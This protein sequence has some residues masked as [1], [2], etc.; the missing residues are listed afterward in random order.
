VITRIQICREARKTDCGKIKQVSFS[1]KQHLNLKTRRRRR[2]DKVA[3]VSTG[4]KLMWRREDALK[5]L[6]ARKIKEL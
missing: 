5:I 4:D 2:N 6:K 1:S 3:E